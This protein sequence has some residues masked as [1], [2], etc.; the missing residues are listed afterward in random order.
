MQSLTP[1][2]AKDIWITTQDPDRS[3]AMKG[4]ENKEV[5]H[6]F[7]ERD[8]EEMKENPELYNHNLKQ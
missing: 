6:N 8:F 5:Y 4:Y 2:E 7:S 3:T 1:E